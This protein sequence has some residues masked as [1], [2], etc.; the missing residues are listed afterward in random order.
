MQR[1]RETGH[2]TGEPQGGCYG[3][4]I[5]IASRQKQW[6]DDV[7]AQ[8]RR[9]GYTATTVDSGIDALTVLVLGLPVDVLV[10]D[11]DLQ[12]DLCCAQLA[13]EARALRPGLKIICASDLAGDASRETA[14]RVPNALFIPLDARNGAAARTVREALCLRA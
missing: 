2:G 14:D 9:A 13:V 7:S 10:T 3:I 1:D 5:L 8:V 6:R 11:V 12:G 4:Q